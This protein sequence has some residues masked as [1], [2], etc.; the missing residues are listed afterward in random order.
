MRFFRIIGCFVILIGGL[1]LSGAEALAGYPVTQITSSWESVDTSRFR[2]ENTVRRFEYG[3]DEN[4][5]LPLPWSFPFYGQL[6]NQII[7]DTN[8]NIWV[9]SSGLENIPIKLPLN[10]PGPAPR[11]SPWNSD[12]SSYLGGGVFAERKTNPDRAVVQWETETWGRHGTY[13]PSRFQVVIYPSGAITF[14]Y[15]N[16]SDPTAA[17]A[18]SGVS[19]SNGVNFTN[20]APNGLVT[21]LSGNS[22][23][24]DSDLDGD[25][26]ADGDDEDDDNDGIPDAWELAHGMN[27]DDPSDAALDPDGDGRSNLDEYL[28]ETDPQS[29]S[30][31]VV[32]TGQAEVTNQWQRVTLPRSFTAPIVIAGPP[33][34]NDA[35]AGVIQLRNVQADSFEIRFKE[36]TYLDGA[37]NAETVSYLVMEDGRHT[38]ADGS[39]WEAGSFYLGASGK[40]SGQV[41]TETFS[42]VPS[43][44]FTAQTSDDVNKPV[45]VRA[46]NVT[47]NGFRAGL[48]T[49]DSLLGKHAQ[50]KV[51]YVAI[52]NSASSGTVPSAAGPLSYDLGS[53]NVGN[54]F[55]QGDGFALRLVEDQSKDIE[56]RHAMEQVN[57]IRIASAF[58]AQ[59]VTMN[60]GDTVVCRHVEGNW[61]AATVARVGVRQGLTWH[62]RQGDEDNDTAA[63]SFGFSDDQ[64]G[65]QVFVGDWNGDGVKTIGMRRGK[66]YYLRHSNTS[67]PADQV[68]TWGETPDR[69]IAGDWDGDGVDTIG[70]KRKTKYYL[71]KTNNASNTYTSFAFGFSTAQAADVPLAGDWNGNG[72]DTIGLKRGNGYYLRNSNNKGNPNYSFTFGDSSDVP[73]VGDWDGNGTDTIG[74]R[75]GATFL[76]RNSHSDGEADL[77]FDFG[78]AGGAPF[79]GRWLEVSNQAPVLK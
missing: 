19:Q 7:A 64:A 65:D 15:H 40:L 41:Y 53:M 8:G 62:L 47:A 31:I 74:V 23:R 67:G 59:P 28:E 37:H 57:L 78:E 72:I 73:V 51:G 13:I 20:I 21:T 29:P 35:A 14:N 63:L 4:I 77:V 70:V 1:A 39:I 24:F 58:F 55:V 50:E 9:S 76:L 46:G 38:M 42:A 36:W 52:W 60:E 68:F 75:Q 27:P 18:G 32:A 3:D 25:G 48:Y 79:G 16:L 43:L 69:V 49:Q 44:L 17:D 71:K 5:I 10:A 2:V 6:F 12:L 45:T 34:Y 54:V 66:V 33:S 61:K 11:I 26:L 30:A 22:Y 56:V